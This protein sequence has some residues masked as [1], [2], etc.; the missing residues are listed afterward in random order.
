VHEVHTGERGKMERV[1]PQKPLAT[2]QYILRWLRMRTRQGKG[3][4]TAIFG[5]LY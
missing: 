4:S 5:R 1:A 2:H 3:T